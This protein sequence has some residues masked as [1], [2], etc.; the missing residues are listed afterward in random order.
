LDNVTHTLV[1]AT[2]ARTK[3]SRAGRGTTAALVLASNAPDIDIVAAAGGS[4]KYLEW[5]R[6]PTHGPLGIIGLGIAT[7]GLVWMGRR[8]RDRWAT[9]RSQPPST[10]P[11]RSTSIERTP[12]APFLMLAAVSIVGVLVH[13]LMDLPTSYG[14]RLLSPFD[15]HWFGADWMPIVDIYLLIVLVASLFG[16]ATPVQAQRKAMIVLVLMAANYGL[17]AATHRQ[18]I[19]LA[20]RL[21]GPTL[22]ELCDAPAPPIKLIDSWPRSSP[23]SPPAPGR[24][25]LIEIAAIPSFVSPFRWRIIAQMSNAYELHD[26]DLLNKEFTDAE[27]ASEAPW[28]LTLRYPNVWTP[29]VLQAAVTH[30]GQKFLAFSRFPAART[31]LDPRGVATV[32]F[33]DVRF[34]GGVTGLDQ[35]APRGGLFTA[36]TRIDTDGRVV[37]EFLGPETTRRR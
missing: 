2:L 17:R 21:F 3:L 1:A 15:W 6:G 26:I 12:D 19:D 14:T 35:P 32:R 36:T 30:L 27:F 20:P 8:V 24:R 5:H 28:R 25:C 9:T 16:R 34:A 18:A 29:L 4:L 31:A 37:E 13:V 10:S 7:A 22:P 11:S 23:P 33:T